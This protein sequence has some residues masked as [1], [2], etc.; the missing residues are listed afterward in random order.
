MSVKLVKMCATNYDSYGKDLKLIGIQWMEKFQ[1]ESD[2][3]MYTAI[4]SCIDYCKKFPTIADI[5]EA[6]R[7]LQYEEQVKP[8]QLEHKTNWNELLADKAFSMVRSGQAKKFLQEVDIGDLVEY[9]RQYFPEISEETVR[10]NLPELYQGQGSQHSCFVC[11]LPNVT[12]CVNHGFV[13]KHWMEKNGR[14]TNQ[15]LACQK[16]FKG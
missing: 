12:E 9:A 2:D 7:D 16:N 11:R 14:I 5:N 6:I 8:K 3:L 1:K 4:L 10:K 13:V 15:M